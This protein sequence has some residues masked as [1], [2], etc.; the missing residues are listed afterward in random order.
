[1]TI[2]R[3]QQTAVTVVT[4]NDP[5]YP[6]NSGNQTGSKTITLSGL[7]YGTYTVT[8]TYSTSTNVQTIPF[9]ANTTVTVNF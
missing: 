8:T 5:M 4:N 1:M 7:Y 2:T 3:N 6:Y 9:T